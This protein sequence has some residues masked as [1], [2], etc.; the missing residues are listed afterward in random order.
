MTRGARATHEKRGEAPGG[1]PQPAVLRL[2]LDRANP[3]PVLRPE[4]DPQGRVNYYL[5][6]DPSRWIEGVPTTSKVRYSGVYPGVDMVLYGNGGQL[7]Y[8]FVIAPGSRPEQIALRFRNDRGRALRPSLNADGALVLKTPSGDFVQHPPRAWQERGSERIAVASSYFLKE[9]GRVGFKLGPYDRSLPLVIDPSLDYSTYLGGSGGDYAMGVKFDTTDDPVVAGITS[10]A[11]FPV[12]D[13]THVHGTANDIF[14]T[15]INWD[16]SGILWS[17]IFGGSYWEY[18]RDVSIDGDDSVYITGQ[19]T[20]SDFPILNGYP[21]VPSAQGKANAF[22][23]RLAASGVMVFSTLI[24]G[25]SGSEMGNCVTT[26]NLGVAYVGG[27]T[28]SS[29]F[30]VYGSPLQST[31]HGSMDGFMTGFDTNQSGMNCLLYSTFLGGYSTDK[32]NGITH[33]TWDG[34]NEFVLVGDT[35]S[36]DFPIVVGAGGP[37]Q[38]SY[39]GGGDAFLAVIQPGQQIPW[40]MSYST[41][42]GGTA[43]DM[44]ERVAAYGRFTIC[45]TGWTAS[46]NFPL[47]M[48]YQGTYG[49]GTSDA[50]VSIFDPTQVGTSSLLYST[51][52]GGSG[53][54]FAYAAA[55]DSVMGFYVAGSTASSNFPIVDPLLGMGTFRGGPEDAFVAHIAYPIMSPTRAPDTLPQLYMS[56]FLGGSGDD[57]AE[58]VGV[59]T[60]YNAV[61]V[62]GTDSLN[63]PVLSPLQSTNGGAYDA[64][65]TRISP[66]SSPCSVTCTAGVTPASGLLTQ[67]F[68]FSSTVTPSGCNGMPTYLWDFG[69]GATSTSAN[70]IHVYSSLGTF[71][72]SLAVTVDA[73]PCVET[74]S[75]TVTAC[76]PTCT[77]SADATSG[78]A[79]LGVTF[80]AGVSGCTGTPSFDWNFGDGSP[81]SA[82]QNPS[83]TYTV[84][85]S[86]TWTMDATQDGTCSKTGT[87]KILDPLQGVP[88][89]WGFNSY[90]QAGDLAANQSSVPA[91]VPG[92]AGLAGLSAGYFHVLAVGTDGTVRAWGSNAAGQLGNGTVNF[93]SSPQLVPGVSGASAVAGGGYHSL[94]VV[95]GGAVKAWGYDYYG[96]LG[97][98]ATGV[99]RLSPVSVTGLTGVT[100]VAAGWNHSLALKGDGTVWSWGYNAGGQLGDGSTTN[101]STPVPV[102][103]LVNIVAI[104]AGSDHSMALRND[105]VVFAWGYNAYGQL[106]N[107]TSIDSGVPVQVA[108]GLAGVTAI[109]CGRYHSVARKNDGTV[110]VWGNNSYGQIGDGTHNMRYSPYVISG[111]SQAAAVGAG[112]WH[113][114]VAKTDGSVLAWGND[115]FG[116]CGGGPFDQKTTPVVVAGASG[117]LRLTA[118]WGFSVA[119]RND[120]TALAWGLN[121]LGQFGNGRSLMRLTPATIAGLA[122]ANAVALGAMHGL[123]L[124][125]DGTVAGWGDNEEGQLGTGGQ[126]FSSPLVTAAGLPGVSGIASGYFH[127]L[128]VKRDGTVWSWGNG[129]HGDGTWVRRLSPGQVPG[130]AGFTAVAAGMDHCLALKG[131][132]TVYAWGIIPEANSATEPR[133]PVTLPSR[134]R[135]SRAWSPS[136]PTTRRNSAWPSRGMAPFGHGATT[137]SASSA[138]GPP[139]TD[140]HPSKCPD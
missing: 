41:Y 110:A 22:L 27:Y 39:G 32:V 35:D 34:G 137:P 99:I 37:F 139:R 128:A 104:A 44:A 105:G 13:G 130:L 72:W 98:G 14:V 42:L 102:S 69:D 63:F 118:G 64:F 45:V 2:S 122:S 87:V 123:A 120:G 52:L 126:S 76:A 95:A 119:R 11:N 29:D 82:L 48:P 111:L 109:A 91:T 106:G 112:W 50:F 47:D 94:A 101:R 33:I 3:S 21:F 25:I 40:V 49:G 55:S 65:V 86:Y 81:H 1:E 51:F 124:R 43:K 8:D 108:G 28:T 20:S 80:S 135:G 133:R 129:P 15:K 77:A 38:I 31:L 89:A 138:T 36:S 46:S 30:P 61:V 125:P 16:G 71:G 93:S 10:S 53:A 134:S 66:A 107:G 88:V 121:D 90:G 62:G 85:G 116:E 92:L 70:P 83:H 131:D 24:K 6:N 100:A 132:G 127:S 97:D 103:G 9:R 96:Q 115:W 84:P 7:E 4:G 5:G 54:D 113:T 58:G 74:G 26:T 68:T 78:F 12:T 75:V 19:A 57:Y 114:L 73:V 56:T 60:S 136:R 117:A 140:S 59:D 18:C 23:T 67:P 17:T 79:P